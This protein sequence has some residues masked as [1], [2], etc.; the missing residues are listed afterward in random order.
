VGKK[1]DGALLPVYECTVL[2][3]RNKLVRAP[4]KRAWSNL[5]KSE[6]GSLLKDAFEAVHVL[7]GV[8]LT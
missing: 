1:D 2:R 6:A 7:S 3:R 4:R 5:N 8:D